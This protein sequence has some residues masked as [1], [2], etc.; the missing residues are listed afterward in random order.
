MKKDLLLLIL[1][2]RKIIKKVDFLLLKTDMTEYKNKSEEK[3]FNLL[4]S[5]FNPKTN[6]INRYPHAHI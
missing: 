5:N 2:T 4:N 1:R 3:C 6:D